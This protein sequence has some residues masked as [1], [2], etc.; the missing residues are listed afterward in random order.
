MRRH[1]DL[2]SGIGGFALAA[3]NVGWNTIGF[4]E[5]DLY[6]QKVLAKNFPG[7]P[8]YDDVR[9]LRG[10]EIG[11]VDI[12]TGGFPCQDISVAGKGAGITGERSGL[13]S[14]LCRIIGDIRPDFAVM[15]NVTA[16]LG[17]GLYRVL[18]DL[19]E[20]G[21]D[22]E[23]HCIPAS[24]VGSPQNRDRIW[25]IAHPSG[26]GVKGLLTRGSISPARSGWA[27]RQEDLQHVYAAPLEGNSWPQPIIRRGN[28]R[29]P[30]WVDRIKGLGNA[31]VPQV[32]EVIFRA[33]DDD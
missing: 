16:L 7:V 9:E 10:E 18:G 20:V 22:A 23:W 19:A 30:N 31:I 15:E 5:I 17:R 12:I 26:N 3:R 27:C 13:W 4:C 24:A 32:A 6:C 1:L 2:F 25:I 33:I 11:P 28:N 29:P 8:I 21:Y 14:E